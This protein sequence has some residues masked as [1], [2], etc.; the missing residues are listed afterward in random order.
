MALNG[1]ICAEVPL[2]NY[3]LTH[4]TAFSTTR[5]WQGACRPEQCTSCSYSLCLRRLIARSLSLCYIL[6]LKLTLTQTLTMA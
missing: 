1:L 3:S 2:K 4:P 6:T 5:D